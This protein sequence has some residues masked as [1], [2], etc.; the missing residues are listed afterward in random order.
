MTLQTERLRMVEQ[1]TGFLDGNGEVDFR[2]LDRDEAYGFVR[3]TLVRLAHP[4][5]DCGTLH[6][7]CG[8]VFSSTVPPAW[9][10][11][12]ETLTV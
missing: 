11:D 8:L 7:D 3:R 12:I 6:V 1:I 10:V 2:P 5:F 9:I 4:D